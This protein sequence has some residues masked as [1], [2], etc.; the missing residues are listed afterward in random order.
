MFIMTPGI[1]SRDQN[2][3]ELFMS[4]HLATEHLVHA[5]INTYIGRSSDITPILIASYRPPPPPP[6]LGAK[7]VFQL[8]MGLICML[9]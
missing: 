8:L 3:L 1:Q 7:V 6:L 2:L 9:V 4:H 5:L